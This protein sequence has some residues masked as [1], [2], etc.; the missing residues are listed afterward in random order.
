MSQVK[1]EEDSKAWILEKFVQK[2]NIKCGMT[3]NG[4]NAA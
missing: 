4:N 1:D 2:M 3:S